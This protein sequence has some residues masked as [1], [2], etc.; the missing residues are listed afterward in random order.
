[1]RIASGF[2]DV[3]ES[4]SMRLKTKIFLLTLLLYSLFSVTL[5]KAQ[6]PVSSIDAL[7]IA[8]WPDY[9]E[10]LV[11]VLITGSLPAD[12][13]LPAEVTIPLPENADVNA[14]ARINSEVGMADISYQI[15]GNTLTLTTPDPQFRVEYYVPYT[16]EGGVRTF[17][18]IWQADL[19]VQELTAEVQQPASAENLSTDPPAVNSVTNPTDGLIYHGISPKVV[20]AGT[21]YE[22][23]FTYNVLDSRLT[24]DEQAP[25]PD[26]AV[27]TPSN[28]GN[29]GSGINWLYVALGLGLLLLVA[30]VTWFVATRYSGNNSNRKPR[31]LHKPRKPSPRRRN[32][33]GQTLFCH[34]CGTAAEKDDRFC[35]NCGTELKR[36]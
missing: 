33:A 8:F 30:A 5:L 6:T 27:I 31:K 36:S 20:P 7:N 12:A 35:R 14:V 3:V 22:L 17:D 19:D 28:T 25:V 24:A 11:L 34:Q 2:A 15:N 13:A 29:Q 23:G 21:P 1:V 10:P 16:D 9:D 32:D 26:T 18:F 4:Y